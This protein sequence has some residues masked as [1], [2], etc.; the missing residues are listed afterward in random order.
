MSTTEYSTIEGNGPS[1]LGWLALLGALIVLGLLSVWHME[2]AGHYVTGMNNG[3][4]WGI[5]HVFAVFLI[6]AASGVLNVASI[7]TVFGKR[8]YEPLGRLSALLAVSLLLGGLVILLLDLGRPDRLIVALTHYN[9]KSIFAW[10]IIFYSG[11]FL[12]VGV[13]LWTMMDHTVY[14]MKKA[15]G[16]LAFIW[17]LMLT[18]CTGALFG[19]L[20]ARTAYDA[21]L[22]APMF[23]IMSFAFGLAC[24]LLV[25][26]AACRWGQ[27]ELGD[28]ILNRMRTLLGIFVAGVLYFVV[29]YH[30]GNL[31]NAEH[32]GIERFILLEG[33]IYTT[34]FWGGQLFLGSLVPLALLFA[35]GLRSERVSLGLS[36]L[37]VIIG[38]LCQMYVIIIA[39]QA[40]PLDIFPGY[41]V[42]ESG[43][44]DG[45]IN[46][47]T[48][49]IY[50]LMLG[51]GGFALALL[52]V[53]FAIRVMAML[54]RS[55]ADSEIDDTSAY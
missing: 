42:I 6:V 10:N 4:V 49:S 11:F 43:F 22:M 20:V 53:T 37:L 3:V 7:A 50:E 46:T 47:Y 19:V 23:I 16:F 18:T 5:P 39:G 36:S 45:V 12:I 2:H 21:V 44:F 52:I 51:L 15:A 30:L 14:G 54:P 35:P 34:L 27:R 29:V 48:P 38:G 26:M 8:I 33:G 9:F 28:A 32:Q 13:Y 31:Y 1:Y 40:Y 41:D 24:F 17:R 55:M 25:L